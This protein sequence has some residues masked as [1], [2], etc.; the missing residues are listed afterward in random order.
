MNGEDTR[1]AILAGCDLIGLNFCPESPRSIS[2]GRAQQLVRVVE[3]TRPPLKRRRKVRTVAVFVN[4]DD[5]LVAGVI[6]HVKPDI[7]QFHGEESPSFCQSWKTPFLKAVALHEPGDV[8]IIP[9]YLG[10]YA[11]GYLI[12]AYD[13]WAHGGTGRRVDVEIARRALEHPRGFLAGGLN[14]ENVGD[15]VRRLKP[16]G[17]DVSSGIEV[18]QGVKSADRMVAFIREVRRAVD[19]GEDG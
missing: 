12:D 8:D 2:F 18:R 19:H 4:P 6:E 10:G 13:P 11:I 9:K 1:Q 17:V 5:E 15:V 16:F 7:L 3:L 14:P